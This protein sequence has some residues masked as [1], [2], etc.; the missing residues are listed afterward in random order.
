MAGES[1]AHVA[2]AEPKEGRRAALAML[3]PVGCAITM[4]A[5]AGWWMVATSQAELRE[6]LRVGQFWFLDGLFALLLGA[7][8]L[9]GRRLIRILD[10]SEKRMLG[11]FTCLAAVLVLVT[12]RTNRIFYDEQIYQAIGQ[13]LSD[14][15]LAQMC[16]DG[17]VEYG[18]LQCWRHEYNK[19]PYGY[20]HLLSLGY[21]WLGTS[22]SVAHWLN[23]IVSGATA[24]TI[25]LLTFVLTRE[26]L[27]S[28]FAAFVFMLLPEQ[29]RWSHSAAVEPSAAF[30]CTLAMLA[31]VAFL[32]YRSTG[33][34]VWMAVSSSWATYFRPE[35]VLILVVIA[36]VVLLHAR[37]EVA[38]PRFLWMM[39]VWVLL[40]LPAVAHLVAVQNESWGSSDARFSL[41][42]FWNNLRTNTAF[43]VG[44]QRFPAVFTLLALAGLSA[45][46]A[47]TAL[48]V[49]FVAFWAVFLFF[50]AGSYDYGA[51]VRFSLMSHAPLAVLAGVGMFRLVRRLT[52]TVAVQRA[53]HI[54]IAALLFQFAWYLPTARA[55]GEEA[56]AARTDVEFA[57]EM[58]GSLPANAV[59]LTHNPGMFHVWGINAAQL[60]IATAD[61]AYVHDTLRRRYAGGVYLHWNFWCNVS[62]PI[63]RAFCDRAFAAYPARLIRERRTRDYRFAFYR[64]TS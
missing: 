30:A 15:H 53:V 8:A 41:P 59:V 61:P 7:T 34:L 48:V 55:V 27:A 22:E 26:R 23:V 58:A 21:R 49:W 39:A 54:A 62:D 6:H 18:T 24:G 60:S 32:E 33:A 20:P 63:Q 16:N 38:R 17:T 29:L 14:L 56:W 19:Q 64:V 40:V 45:S 57:R 25:F 3:L 31:T 5:L 9:A 13:N 10:G 51:D 37:D 12:P 42:F 4:T 44:D 46:R 11:I 1:R 36:V 50:Y 47:T 52:G 35:A 43:Y 28:G 2:P